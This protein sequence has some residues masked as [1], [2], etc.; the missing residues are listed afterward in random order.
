MLTALSQAKSKYGIILAQN[1]Y[2]IKEQI[3]LLSYM[4]VY[5][6]FELSLC[7]LIQSSSCRGG[8]HGKHG[9]DWQQSS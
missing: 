8:K 7:R 6:K 1:Y 5:I 9:Q 4:H 3:Q 2:F